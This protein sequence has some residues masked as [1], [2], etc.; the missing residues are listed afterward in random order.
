MDTKPSI[1]PHIVLVITRLDRGGSA[2]LTL[3]LAAGLV[4]KGYQITLIA[5]QTSQPLGSPQTFA[6]QNHFTL[7]YLNSLR[8]PISPLNDMLAF[9]RLIFLLKKLRPDILHTN[10]SKAGLIG[11]LAGKLA[12]VRKIFHSPHGHIFYG[13]YS[14][15][16]SRLFIILEKYMAHYTD[17]IL[18][19][20]ERGRRDHIRARIA[21]P[22]KFMVSSCGVE[23]EPFR[24]V[25]SKNLR[26][27]DPQNLVVIW[28]GR[29][30]PVKN[31]PLLL[32]AARLLQPQALNIRYI[33]AGDGEDAEK[34]RNLRD[35]YNIRNIEFLGF[36]NDLPAIFAEGDVFIL[37]SL[38]EGFG[39]ILVEAM[40]T[41]LA[42]IATNVGGVP[43]IIQDGINGIL[44][45]SRDK[46]QLAG[47][48]R[49][50]YR[51]PKLRHQMGLRN[52]KKAEF[53]SISNYIKKVV[54]IYQHYCP[55]KS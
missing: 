6:A 46:Q 31:L 53:Y 43:E 22:E 13:Y 45:P 12:G 51:N 30:V 47:A 24:A 49:K 10:S 33:I 26:R 11:R 4:K 39:R 7:H 50:I 52:R 14:P 20:T 55:V 38:N 34:I 48:I 15:T 37:T 23:L 32:E 44:I 29:L 3:Q 16:I 8:R 17:K 5:G 42:L 1:N 2:E 21:P 40:A 18:N 25:T 35:S 36:R 41:G 27:S 54:Y 19:L 28:A 9:L